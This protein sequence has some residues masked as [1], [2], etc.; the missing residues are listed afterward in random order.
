MRKLSH[1]RMSLVA[2]PA[3][4]SDVVSQVQ[5]G[6]TVL[7]PA[8]NEAASIADTI[9][10]LRNQTMPPAEIIVID[11]CSTDDTAEVARALWRHRHSAARVNTGSKA[12]AQNYALQLSRRNLRW[13]STPTPPSR[14]TRSSVSWR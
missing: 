12:G 9:V 5:S 6:V 4:V 8:Y 11:D 14:R 10:S 7:V 2:F 1:F 3:E 13:R